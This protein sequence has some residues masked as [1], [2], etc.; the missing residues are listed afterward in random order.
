MN[1]SSMADRVVVAF[2]TLSMAAAALFAYT[3]KHDYDTRGRQVASVAQNGPADVGPGATDAAGNPSTDSSGVA[4]GTTSGGGGRGARSTAAGAVAT[5]QAASGVTKDKILVGGIYDMTG[6]VDSSVERDTVRAYFA[7]VNS[8]GGVNG[9]QLV[10][11]PCDGYYDKVHSQQCA[12]TMVDNKVLATV[13]NTFPGAENDTVA[14]L[15]KQGIPSVGGL[16][17]PNEYNNALSYPVSPSFSFAGNAL[18]AQIKQ[19]QQ[20]HPGLYQHPAIL[21]ISDVDWVAPVIK[22]VEDALAG[23]GV[24]PTH[25][26]KASATNDPDYTQHVANL[27]NKNDGDPDTG[28]KGPCASPPESVGAC[29]DSIIAATDPFSYSKLFQAMDRVNWHPPVVAGGLDKGNVQSTYGDQLGCSSCGTG[30]ASR[31]AESETPFL[32]PLDPANAG[33]P[34]V[35]DYLTTMQRYFPGQ[36]TALDVYTQITWSA[37]QVFVEAAKRAGPNLTRDTLVAQLNQLKNFDTGWA[38]PISYSAGGGHDPDHCYYF[39]RHDA[40]SSDQGGTWR[41]Y[42]PLRCL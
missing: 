39:M 42:T 29:P 14:Y 6:P 32:S 38:T 17:V 8:Q 40:K 18:A 5:T 10:L 9:R 22:A 19:L 12:T 7:K 34:T 2:I 28:D 11:V 41:Q 35:K 21:Y 36:V 24:H 15:N 33:N 23:I 4:A 31:Q 13:G 16:G 30:G 25:V 20:A 1:S 37:A 3:I 26:E 27:E